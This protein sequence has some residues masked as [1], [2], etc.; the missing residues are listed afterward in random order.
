MSQSRGNLQTDGRTDGQTLFHRTLPTETGS[1]ITDKVNLMVKTGELTSTLFVLTLDKE[2]K[3]AYIF[4]T[5][6]FEA[7]KGLEGLHKTF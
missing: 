2:G 6:L 4:F 1:S 7:S 5:L 3:I